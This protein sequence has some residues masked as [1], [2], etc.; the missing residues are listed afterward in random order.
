MNGQLRRGSNMLVRSTSDNSENSHT[1][2]S[3]TDQAREHENQQY[4]GEIWKVKTKCL[5]RDKTSGTA[6]S[7][8]WNLQCKVTRWVDIS[9]NLVQIRYDG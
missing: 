6:E 2:Q 4:L 5:C 7:V 1:P 9:H 3:T 8:S